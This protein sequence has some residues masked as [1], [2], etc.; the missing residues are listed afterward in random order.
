ERAYTQ[1]GLFSYQA[2]ML[3]MQIYGTYEGRPA[4]GVRVG[5]RL[6]AAY[7]ENPDVRFAL[8]GLYLGPAGGGFG[9]AGGPH[10]EGGRP[11]AGAPPARRGVAPRP[12]RADV[13]AAAAMAARRG[14]HDRDGD[15][16]REAVE[17]GLG[18]AQL[19]ASP[20][21]PAGAR[22][23]PRSGRGRAPRARR[24]EVERA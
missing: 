10:R 20:R 15:D 11:G 21:E 1:G 2:G 12:P 23:R 8:A 22:R 18:D 3:L 6:A 13:G 7:P 19:P 16:R 14:D 17:A 5:E 9:P 24:A 4:E